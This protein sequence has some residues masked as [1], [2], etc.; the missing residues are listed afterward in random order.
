[1]SE[2]QKSQ[3]PASVLDAVKSSLRKGQAPAT[4]DVSDSSPQQEPEPESVQKPDPKPAT[5]VADKETEQDDGNE[6][7]VPYDRFKQVNSKFKQEQARAERLEQELAKLR[8]KAS[9]ARDSEEVEELL[10]AEDKPKNFDDLSIDHQTAWYA[11]QAAKRALQ[12]ELGDVLPDIKSVA[13][14]RRM[15]KALGTTLTAEQADLIGDV[16]SD[17]PG[18]APA[19]ALV[20][21]K[22]RKP[23]L[24]GEQGGRSIPASHSVNDPRQGSRTENRAR[25]DQGKFLKKMSEE[26][27]RAQRQRIAVEF[28]KSQLKKK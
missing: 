14:Q 26:P 7:A 22:N 15:S 16:L 18:L 20:L 23:E 4:Q 19:E 27:S 6:K 25:D 24:F 28:V 21:A 2:I 3:I 11:K 17:A 5:K 9:K 1:M 10:S 13:M 12:H 8:A